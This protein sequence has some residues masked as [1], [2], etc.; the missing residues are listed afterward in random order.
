MFD[1]YYKPLFLRDPADKEFQEYTKLFDAFIEALRVAE[2]DIPKTKRGPLLDELQKKHNLLSRKLAAQTYVL[3]ANL[4]MDGD[5]DMRSY[6]GHYNIN[7]IRCAYDNDMMRGPITQLFPKFDRNKEYTYT[8]QDLLDQLK[9]KQTLTV[10]EVISLCDYCNALSC[11]VI[12]KIQKALDQSS[13][14]M[15]NKIQEDLI[16]ISSMAEAV[17]MHAT[18]RKGNSKANKQILEDEVIQSGICHLFKLLFLFTRQFS[19]DINELG[20]EQPPTLDSTFQ[21]CSAE[22]VLPDTAM[23]QQ[24]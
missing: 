20:V 17:R 4:K 9:A 13:S 23:E 8:N 12:D 22:Q 19:I 15:V 2:I 1:K 18:K 24:R 6:V 10:K 7:Y 16:S 21:P 5:D 14:F 3:L 11:K